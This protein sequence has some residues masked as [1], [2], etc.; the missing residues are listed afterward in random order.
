MYENTPFLILSLQSI[1]FKKK[2]K[3][4]RKSKGKKCSLYN[5]TTTM[6]NNNLYLNVPYLHS[7]F[8]QG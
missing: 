4:E 6:H 3:I 8:V 2:K 1:K 7:R 5:A